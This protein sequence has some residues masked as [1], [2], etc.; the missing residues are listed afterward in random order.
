MLGCPI[1]SRSNNTG[2]P[3]GSLEG[4]S[5]NSNEGMLLN[6]R[7]TA[8]KNSPSQRQVPSHL[9]PVLSA[10]TK[11]SKNMNV[12]YTKTCTKDL[13]ITAVDL[14]MTETLLNGTSKA[15]GVVVQK[16]PDSARPAVEE[17]TFHFSP[18]TIQPNCEYGL[19]KTHATRTEK[20]ALYSCFIG[21]T[22][23]LSAIVW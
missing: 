5:T 11:N 13:S 10:T 17:V 9:Y 20:I 8:A 7:Q 6:Q 14:K 12:E 18:N 4:F 21:L 19:T 3:N 22:F 16:T 1:M 23:I 15:G 2:M